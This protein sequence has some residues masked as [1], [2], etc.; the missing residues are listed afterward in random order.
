MKRPTLYDVDGCHYVCAGDGSARHYYEEVPPALRLPRDARRFWNRWCLQ[1]AENAV[2]AVV[3]RRLVG[4]FRFF[5]EDG[6]VCF[7][8]NAAGTWVHPSYRRRG[9]AL[10]MW[11]RAQKIHRCRE[12]R[13]VTVSEGGQALIAAFKKDHPKLTVWL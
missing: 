10:R 8:M 13:V 2:I 6:D 12:V 4:F 9:L 1:P 11:N 7:V 3:N 5:F